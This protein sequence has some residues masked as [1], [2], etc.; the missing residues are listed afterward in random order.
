MKVC[1]MQVVG[2]MGDECKVFMKDCLLVK[3]VKVMM[4][5]EKMKVC[6]MQVIG[7]KGDDCKVFMKSC[8]SNQLVV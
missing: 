2:K 4:Q 6:N 7:K 5:Q 8:L 1:N 3:F